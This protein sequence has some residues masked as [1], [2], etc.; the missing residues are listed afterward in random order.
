[1]KMLSN[2]KL[3]NQVSWIIVVGL[4]LF[5]GWEK[6]LDAQ[7]LMVFSIAVGTQLL[8]EIKSFKYKEWLIVIIQS[9]LFIALV[10]VSGNL[11]STLIWA[12]LLPV[13]G[14]AIRKGLLAAVGMPIGLFVSLF[15]I[16]SPVISLN[17]FVRLIWMPFGAAL[18][19][20]LIMAFLFNK[21]TM[22]SI[23]NEDIARNKKKE[24][25]R[26]ERKRKKSMFEVSETLGAAL[27]F[28][29]VLE[30][31]LDFIDNTINEN[32]TELNNLHSSVL[33]VNKDSFQVSAARRYSYS[34]LEINF[35][36][37]EGI[38]AKVANEGIA[39]LIKDPKSDNELARIS[40]IHTMNV[41]LCYPL[42]SGV[43]LFGLLL[44]AHEDGE[45][46]S[47]DRM[48][49]IESIAQQLSSSL[50]N[51]QLYESLEYEKERITHIEEQARRQLARNLHDGP[52]QSI[53]AIAMRVNLARRMI[54]KDIEGASAELF[55]I[56]ELA[57]RTTKEIR[58]M[59]FTLR[60]EILEKEGFA[61]AIRD[62]AGNIE[63]NYQ[64]S[65]QIDLDA[66]ALIKM[67][68]G[69]QGVL[70]NVAVEALTNALK[71]SEAENIS[72]NLKEMERDIARMEIEDDGKGF[73]P[74]SEDYQAAHSDQSG[75]RNMQD[76][77]ELLNGL[78]RIES[79]P[80]MGCKI[81]IWVPMNEKA[82]MKL[83]QG[84]N[85]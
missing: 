71:H 47:Q 16:F 17:E 83:R 12:A 69:R 43:D 56:E 42:N 30:L 32:V 7:M 22:N 46:F 36:A 28:D 44:L 62:L 35:N 64:K 76:R 48:I 38:L 60:P 81:Q 72:I 24:T 53:A 40:F 9:L 37:K 6:L 73:V 54:A 25:I 13:V 39:Q 26:M 58:H 33:L 8:I 4:A 85:A 27:D 20:G 1:M 41:A 75:I 31:A 10:Y 21:W 29:H 52:T 84:M 63:N 51:A 50:K 34:D 82:A 15:L 2:D 45:Y 18:F 77:V 66:K 65:I 55:K 49:Q 23:Q 61:P 57:R 68:L 80:G 5:A 70:F 59:L 3:S 74:F 14:I 79:S 11:Q 67:D 78:F 19:A